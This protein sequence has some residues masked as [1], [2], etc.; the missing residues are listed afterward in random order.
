MLFKRQVLNK[1]NTVNLT[2][3]ANPARLYAAQEIFEKQPHAKSRH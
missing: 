2:P 1:D 3:A